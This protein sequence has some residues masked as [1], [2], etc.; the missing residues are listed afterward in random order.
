M[1][2]A[3]VSPQD[4]AIDSLHQLIADGLRGEARKIIAEAI[5][6]LELLGKVPTAEDYAQLRTG[7]LSDP[8]RQGFKLVAQA[9]SKVW[10]Y[11]YRDSAGKTCDLKLG[12]YP[13]ISLEA[14]RELWQAAHNAARNGANPVA[15]VRPAS[16]TV[17]GKELVTRYLA[18]YATRKRDKGKGDGDLLYRDFVPAFGDAWADKLTRRDIQQLID[19]VSARGPRAGSKL[20]AVIRKMFN[21]AIK[22]E[23]VSMAVNPCAGVD[24]LAKPST[25]AKGPHLDE[26]RLKVFLAGLPAAAMHDTTKIILGLLLTTASRPSEICELYWDEVDLEAGVITLPGFSDCRK[27]REHRITKNGMAHRI[28]LS[29]QDVAI[30]KQ[31]QQ[32]TGRTTGHVFPAIKS[33]DRPYDLCHL[34]SS[35]KQNRELL[36]LGGL[37]F[38]PH[39]LRHTAVTLLASGGYTKEVRDRVTNHVDRQSVD[40]IYNQFEY[41]KPAREALQWLSDKVEAAARGKK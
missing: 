4:K 29:R 36:G 33:N 15:S 14:A 18:E 39:S 9:R 12:E 20:F 13:A 31:W 32:T 8:S 10:Q 21:H 5:E 3:I 38:T 40:S 35:L 16:G 26:K 17:T 25:K 28:M 30:L 7:S 24:L 37:K 22:R 23:W 6:R 1:T 11:R 2:S 34:A 27:G 19:E 41:D